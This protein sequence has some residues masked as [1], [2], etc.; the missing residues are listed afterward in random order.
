MN[1]VTKIPQATAKLVK[2][3]NG[4]AEKLHSV[5]VKV[6]GVFGIQ[7]P[8]APAEGAD[9][10]RAMDGFVA[11]SLAAAEVFGEVEAMLED[12]LSEPEQTPEPVQIE[13]ST[14]PAIE[15][16]EPAP[17]TLTIPADAEPDPFC[18]K[19]EA[20]AQER[21]ESIANMSSEEPD[22][23][24]DGDPVNRMA[25]YETEPSSNGRHGGR[26]TKGR[27]RKGA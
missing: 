7:A 15:V 9:L 6:A 4:A 23:L 1:E 3:I 27:K 2:S 10:N 12:F 18:E 21:E 25:S 16:H 14:P 5:A 17:E 26:A 24:P 22:F 13:Q 8:A 19:E 20:I 11:G